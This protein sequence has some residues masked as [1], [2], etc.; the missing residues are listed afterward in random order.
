M[1]PEKIRNV[2]LVGHGG[3]GK[4]SLAEALLHVSGVTSRLGSVDAGTSLLDHTP[5]EQERKISLELATAVVEWHDHRIN[6]IDTPG[7]ADFAGDARAAL[8]AADLA[9]FVVSAVDGVE[10][11]TELMWRA[12]AEEGIPR[13]IMITKLDRERASFDRT[14]AQLREAFGKRV[15]P[16]QVPIGSESSLTGV[17][18]V[19][20]G[21]CY[22]YAR[23]AKT[24]TLI[25]TPDEVADLIAATH[26]SLIESVVETDD[27]LMEA[28][29]EG[30]EPERDIIVKTVHQGMLD[31]EIFPVLV[32]SSTNLVGIDLF[33]EFLVD[34]A[35]NP[36]ER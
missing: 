12:A 14:L 1:I 10:V 31:A 22:D 24:G 11:G 7:Y 2:A 17:A 18:R 28:Y 6:L 21:R 27:A 20:S 35:P 36:L 8:R 29:F 26:T 23:G 16:I 15:A 34:F 13:A 9:L 33:G 19:V 4:T 5:E 30:V 3:S 32:S 25:D